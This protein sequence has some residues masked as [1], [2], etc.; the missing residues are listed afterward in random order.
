ME[1]VIAPSDGN[2]NKYWGYTTTADWL[3]LGR[4][5][6]ELPMSLLFAPVAWLL[7]LALWQRRRARPVSGDALFFVGVLGLGALVLPVAVTTAS[8]SEPQ[9]IVLALYLGAGLAGQAAWRAWRERAVPLE[10]R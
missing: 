1:E 6:V 4:L 5:R 3:G 8:G 10:V 9:A 2:L 7:A